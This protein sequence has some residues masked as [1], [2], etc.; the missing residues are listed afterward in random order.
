MTTVE[1]IGR[2]RRSYFVQRQSVREIAR[3]LH[4]SR[5]T[6][7]KAIEVEDGKFSYDRTVQPMPK[8][9]AHV[10]E[11][12][13]LLAE[14]ERKPRRERLTL[15]RLFEALRAQ[16]YE[17]G[18][19]TVRRHARRWQR[20]EAGRT[21]TAFVPLSF[22]PGEAYQFDWSHEVV[23]LAGGTTTVKVA[24]MRLCHSRM[25]FVRSYP[26]E[27]QEMVFDAHARAFAFFGG[28]CTRGIYDNLWTPPAARCFRSGALGLVCVNLSGLLLERFRPWP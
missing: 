21:A 26:R 14:N 22:E 11:L 10:A 13:R 8:L 5:K 18:Y 25:F 7:R 3:R 17:G 15:I 12:E 2:I 27:T 23:V 20:E 4:V 28:V 9:G 24:H 6:V 19:D 1:T 16:G